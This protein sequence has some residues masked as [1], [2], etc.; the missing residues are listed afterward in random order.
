[1]I[2][3]ITKTMNL[4]VKGKKARGKESS[5][6]ESS[7]MESTHRADYLKA[8]WACYDIL[9]AYVNSQDPML[10]N[11]KDSNVYDGFSLIKDLSDGIAHI[12][13]GECSAAKM[14]YN[15]KLHSVRLL[16]GDS[17]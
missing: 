15:G 13:N 7:G 6:K 14:Y 12:L 1:M 9:P 3:Q 10:C 17:K 11:F 2:S 16:D 4:L 8:L 5:D